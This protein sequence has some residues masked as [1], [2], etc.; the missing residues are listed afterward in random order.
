MESSNE[1]ELVSPDNSNLSEMEISTPVDNKSGVILYE[2][3]YLLEKLEKDHNKDEMINIINDMVGILRP[4]IILYDA[5]TFY[6]QDDVNKYIN[7]LKEIFTNHKKLIKYIFKIDRVIPINSVNGRIF[8]LKTLS[9]KYKTSKLLVKVAAKETSDPISYEYY[10][11][12]AL[13]R[14]RIDYNIDFFAVMY[15]RFFCGLDPTIDVNEGDL[16][17]I[18]LCDNRYNKK[19]HLLYEFIRNIETEEVLTLNDYIETLRSDK[20]LEKEINIINVIILVLYALQEAQDKMEFTH[21]DLHAKNILVVKLSEV[22]EYNLVYK[23]ESITIVTDVV[24]HIIDYG[25]S[26]INPETA[27]SENGAFK[28]YELNVEFSDFELYQNV[29]FKKYVLSRN[30]NLEKIKRI[31]RH[32]NKLTNRYLYKTESVEIVETVETLEFKKGILEVYYNGE[33]EII[34]NEFKIIKCDFGIDTRRGHKK[35]DFFRICRIVGGMISNISKEKYLYSQNIWKN[36]GDKLELQYP[37]H[38]GWYYSLVSDYNPNP[39]GIMTDDSSFNEPID[40][41]NYLYNKIYTKEQFG[42]TNKKNGKEKNSKDI[43]M[44]NEKIKRLDLE[45]IK[46][47]LENEKIKYDFMDI[48]YSD[49]NT[50]SFNMKVD[51]DDKN[52]N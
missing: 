21:Y 32:L 14:L 7:I 29:L 20:T 49:M 45:S 38:D 8:I 41:V 23:G 13:N 46:R 12:L 37:Y 27:I 18:E 16:K 2:L 24:P 31:E 40:I 52:K 9:N 28:D 22:K 33:S 50:G 30:K 43:N 10:V 3:R 11:G 17:D 5:D 1:M 44:N 39:I 48:D 15:G 6:L 36:L 34:D 4:L 42:G 35:Y 25:R 47:K 26:H 51:N 19:T